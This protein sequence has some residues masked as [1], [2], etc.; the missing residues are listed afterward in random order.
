MEKVSIKFGS[1]EKK[2]CVLLCYYVVV[3]LL[4]LTGVTVDSRTGLDYAR[5]E[6]LYFTC[7]SGGRKVDEPC[8]RASLE[9]FNSAGIV[10][11]SFILVG[12]IPMVNFLLTIKYSEVL[13]ILKRCTGR[14]SVTE[15]EM[16]DQTS[17]TKYTSATN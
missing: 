2:T 13:R 15:M 7:E 1:A 12:M 17:S 11:M 6:L 4:G 14:R 16:S 10:I 5:Q 3:S 9:D 8:I